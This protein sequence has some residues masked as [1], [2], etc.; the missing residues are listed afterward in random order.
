MFRLREGSNKKRVFS[1]SSGWIE[2][3]DVAGSLMD[4]GFSASRDASQIGTSA[5]SVGEFRSVGGCGAVQLLAG[6]VERVP[7]GLGDPRPHERPAMI[8][9]ET[10]KEVV[11]VHACELSACVAPLGPVP[12]SRFADTGTRCPRSLDR[13]RSS[14]PVLRSC[15]AKTDHAPGAGD[16]PLWSRRSGRSVKA[17]SGTFP[18]SWRPYGLSEGSSSKD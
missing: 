7:L 10:F 15:R 6:G 9:D 16:R 12:H 5:E 1:E 17:S 8:L 18:P 3:G 13:M 14:E 11:D 4:A 2:G